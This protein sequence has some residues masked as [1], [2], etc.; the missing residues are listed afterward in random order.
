MQHINVLEYTNVILVI[1]L[2]PHHYDTS[3]SKPINLCIHTISN[4]LL[5]LE[6]ATVFLFAWIIMCF[7]YLY[8]SNIKVCSSFVKYAT[9]LPV[10]LSMI[11]IGHMLQTP[12]LFM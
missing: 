12:P 8:F 10:D 6:A 2:L 3:S 11:A 1:I 9:L 4:F 5:H 7:T